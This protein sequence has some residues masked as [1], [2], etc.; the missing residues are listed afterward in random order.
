[1]VNWWA[2]ITAKVDADEQAEALRV[3]IQKRLEMAKQLGE[4]VRV[5]TAGRKAQADD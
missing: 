1:M 4:A 5:Q 2:R 3:S